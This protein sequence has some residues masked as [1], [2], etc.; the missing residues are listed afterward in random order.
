MK[1]V[2]MG[3]HFNTIAIIIMQSVIA[4]MA[5]APLKHVPNVP[6]RLNGEIEKRK[7][8]GIEHVRNVNDY[9]ESND[10]LS[11]NDVNSDTDVRR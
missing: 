8:L 5:V 7:K 9:E 6:P 3:V 11:N 1:D 2:F 10:R 4:T